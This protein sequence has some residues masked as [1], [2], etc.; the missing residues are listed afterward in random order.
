[1]LGSNSNSLNRPRIKE[2]NALKF[3]LLSLFVG[4]VLLGRGL[5][6]KMERLE[7]LVCLE[8]IEM[9]TILCI[10]VGGLGC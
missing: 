4:A 7:Y 8:L 9:L 3:P 2:N 10:T 1:M 6:M 5:R